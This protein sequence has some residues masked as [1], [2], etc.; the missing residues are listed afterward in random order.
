MSNQP[1]SEAE[2]SFTERDMEQAVQMAR[3][4][5]ID[6]ICG[7]LEKQYEQTFTVTRIISDPGILRVRLILQTKDEVKVNFTAEL[8]TSEEIRET[9]VRSRCLNELKAAIEDALP[10]T[11]VNAVLLED[12]VP[13][14]DMALSFPE[15]LRKHDVRRILVRLIAEEDSAPERDEII[16]T[17][18]S[19]SRDFGADIAVYYFALGGEGFQRCRQKFCDLPSVS[20]TM[21]RGCLPTAEFSALVEDGVVRALK[22]N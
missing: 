13:E 7:Q 15:Y 6:Y 19:V 10:G 9:Y 1:R 8:D 2:I 12:Y 5:L 22:V 21:I 20:R 16:R 3:K 14:T 17:I 18:E 4:D 11:A